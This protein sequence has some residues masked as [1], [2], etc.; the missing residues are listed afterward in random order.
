M[1]SIDSLAMALLALVGSSLV[2]GSGLLASAQMMGMMGS[3]E[4]KVD[5]A[6]APDPVVVGVKTT[7]TFSVYNKTSGLPITGGL[8]W[9]HFS[10]G[11]GAMMP[12]LRAPGGVEAAPGVYK[13]EV[14][15]NRTGDYTFHF[16]IFPL[17]H[18]KRV[19]MMERGFGHHDFDIR[20][21][22]KPPAETPPTAQPTSRDGAAPALD[23]R[24]LPTIAAALVMAC[25]L[26]FFRR[27]PKPRLITGLALVVLLAILSYQALYAPHPTSEPTRP[28]VI[29]IAAGSS[30]PYEEKTFTPQVAR[31]FIGMNN[32]VIWR[33]GDVSAHTITE[34]AGRFRSPLINPGKDWT[35]TFTAPGTYEYYCM[36]HPWMRGTIIVQAA[37]LA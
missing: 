14:V 29:W 6:Y 8:I 28:S 12:M 19:G 23:Y 20:V 9:N 4:Y 2:L 31:V 37:A 15:F 25:L 26:I 16:H 18:G 22:D 27:R 13:V 17:I 11:F 3:D 10:P 5:I 32:T 33:N 1:K 24:L 21:V 30:Y 7:F 35:Y 36:P 34:D